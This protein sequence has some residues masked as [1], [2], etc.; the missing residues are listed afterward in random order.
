MSFMNDRVRGAR[1]RQKQALIAEAGKIGAQV[2]EIVEFGD[3]ARAASGAIGGSLTALIGG[4]MRVDAVM[5]VRLQTNGWTHFYAQPFSGF[6]PLPGEHHGILPGCLATPAILRE[7][8]R[9]GD[10][11]WDPAAGPEVARQLTSSPQVRQAI[12]SIA[13]EWAIGLTKVTIDWA[14]QLRSVGDGTTHVVMQSGR[15]GGI[16]TY[17]VGFAQWMQVCQALHSCLAGWAPAAQPFPV[18]TAH[19][20]LIGSH[21]GSTPTPTPIPEPYAVTVDYVATVRQALAAYVGKKVWIGGET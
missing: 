4:S 11:P 3:D 9:Y 2:V 17:D 8:L 21:T 18:P 15:Y 14:I 19:A 7:E 13:W 10:H 6:N 16:T 20:E 12:R 5:L 1:D